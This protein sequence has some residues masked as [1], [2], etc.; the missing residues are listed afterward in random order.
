VLLA[1]LA[2]ACGGGNTS[3]EANDAPVTSP[4]RGLLVEFDAAEDGAIQRIVVEADDGRRLAF[5]VQ[6]APDAPVTA[7]HLQLHIDDDWPVLVA[8]TGE[9]DGR[10]AHRIDDG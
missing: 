5:A 3:G 9:G 1:G 6:L 10:V 8:F 4:V 2:S 7:D